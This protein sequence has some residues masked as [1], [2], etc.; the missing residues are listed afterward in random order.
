MK[1]RG[2][3]SARV[4]SIKE[5][6]ETPLEGDK[7]MQSRLA[8]DE[9]NAGGDRETISEDG[10]RG[11][12]DLARHDV[13]GARD[14]CGAGRGGR[15]PGGRRSARAR[16]ADGSPQGAGPFQHRLFSLPCLRQRADPH[17]RSG[18]PSS[19]ALSVFQCITASLLV[20]RIEKPPCGEFDGRTNKSQ[21]NRHARFLSKRI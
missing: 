15:V 1:W 21:C 8:E 2:I 20:V 19:D 10:G 16:L 7:E 4:R 17:G 6:A 9:E 18:H 3:F 12:V 5:A 11:H 14:P 13:A